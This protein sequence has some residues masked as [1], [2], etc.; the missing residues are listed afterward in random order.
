MKD[1]LIM[2]S[3]PPIGVR[4]RGPAAEV[5]RPIL[6]TYLNGAVGITGCQSYGIARE[7]CEYDVVIVTNEERSPTSVRMGYAYM[8]I[9]FV[10]EKEVMKPTDPE[11][12]VALASLQQVRDQTL[13]LSTST[14]AN[15]AV[16]AENAKRA[17]EFRLRS[18][19]KDLG[20]V[21]ESLS[22]GL[23]HD[24]DFWLVTSAYDFASSWLLS[25][26]TP[27]SPSHLLDLLKSRSAERPEW[28]KAFSESA[29]LQNAS[30]RAC[31]QRLDGLSVIMDVM[32]SRRG[33]E[34]DEPAS[35]S[36]RTEFEI[37]RQKADYLTEAIRHVDC[38]TYL[39]V[40]VARVLPQVPRHQGQEL[41]D[42][43]MTPVITALTE[44]QERVFSEGVMQSLGLS[45]TAEEVKKDATSIREA[46]SELAKTI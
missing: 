15:R 18:T 32:G 43:A 6:D 37:M 26:E 22:A 20:R 13:V 28:F 11:V 12:A 7:C 1:N 40:E 30:R 9:L 27:L 19:L 8:D 21:D 33:A 25:T 10:S 17:A 44:G 36:N 4:E 29:G 24:A 2:R 14:S 42:S 39:G 31:A 5:V 41:T 34:D 46:V 35:P 23:A 16:L 45:R 38:F 3:G